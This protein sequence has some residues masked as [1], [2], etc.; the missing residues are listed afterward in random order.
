MKIQIIFL[1]AF[2]LNAFSQDIEA[3]NQKLKQDISDLEIQLFNINRLVENY[4]DGELN[5]GSFLEVYNQNEVLTTQNVNLKNQNDVLLSKLEKTKIELK[6]QNDE[7]LSKLEKTKIELK[8]AINDYESIYEINSALVL[9]N[10]EANA[11]ISDNAS[12]FKSKNKKIDILES[13]NKSLKNKISDLNLELSQ[14]KAFH[15]VNI[16]ELSSQHNSIVKKLNDKILKQENSSYLLKNKIDSTNY[17]IK[18]L[19]ATNKVLENDLFDQEAISNQFAKSFSDLLYKN[20]KIC[21]LFKIV[22]SDI[23]ITK[24]K[25]RVYLGEFDQPLKSAYL[26]DLVC[27][28]NLNNKFYC[29]SGKFNDEVKAIKYK[30]IMFGAGYQSQLIKF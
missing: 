30:N 9:E 8:K 20:N 26:E 21:K 15:K 5:K 17:L 3:E 19:R 2:S 16:N 25:Y 13:N 27:L 18:D 7:L 6:N 22:D 12:K 11:L 24:E 23:F 10:D 4:I 28:P 29:Y 1:L 14:T